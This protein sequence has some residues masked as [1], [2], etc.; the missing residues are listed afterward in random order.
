M[1]QGLASDR[2]QNSAVVKAYITV[3]GGGVGGGD[4]YYYY[5][6]YYYYRAGYL[7]GI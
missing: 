2:T 3:V 1:P 4:Y 5:Y 7:P 6:Y